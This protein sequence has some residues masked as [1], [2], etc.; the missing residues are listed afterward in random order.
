MDGSPYAGQTWAVG[1]ELI[2]KTAA[3]AAAIIEG[4]LAAPCAQVTYLASPVGITTDFWQLF[5][6]CFLKITV[7][8]ARLGYP[9]IRPGDC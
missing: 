8:R 3:H 9:A 6:M 5:D 7:A 4:L 2:P 1:V